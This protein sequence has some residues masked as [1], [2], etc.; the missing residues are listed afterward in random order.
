VRSHSAVRC[1]AR[2]VVTVL[3]LLLFAAL[4]PCLANATPIATQHPAINDGFGS[5]ADIPLFMFDDFTVVSATTARSVTWTGLY[6]P[7]VGPLPVDAFTINFFENNAGQVGSL[8]ASFTPGNAVHRTATGITIPAGY[9]LFNYAADLGSG[10]ALASGGHYWLSIYNDT[11]GDTH[12]WNWATN[13]N[14]GSLI[15]VG[16]SGAF[17]GLNESAYFAV[18]DANLAEVPVPEPATLSLL[19]LGLGAIATRYRRNRR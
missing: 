8:L 13:G 3:L 17:F 6:A 15:F 2:R 16:E 4:V 11:T 5:D 7:I 10:L 1:Q 14:T 9:E 18:D 19:G 12:T